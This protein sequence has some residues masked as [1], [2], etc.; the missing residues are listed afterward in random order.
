MHQR[1]FLAALD[2]KK[3]EEA[4]G[5]A[6]SMTSGEIRVHVRVDQGIAARGAGGV[7]GVARRPIDDAAACRGRCRHLDGRRGS[8]PRG[9]SSSSAPAPAPASAA[10]AR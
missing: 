5:T 4:I 2:Q 9:R 7:K 1:D 3:I 6:E 10:R 8:A